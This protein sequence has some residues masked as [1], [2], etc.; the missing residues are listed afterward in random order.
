[1]PDIEGQAPQPPSGPRLLAWT[2]A[3][4]VVAAAITVCFV[5]PA[6][7]HRDPLGV[8]KLTGLGRLAAPKEVAAPAPPA[9]AAA[10]PARFYSAPWRTDEIV[11]DLPGD[12]A[13]GSE[14]EYKV[15]MKPGATLVY[16]WSETG[17]PPEEF[18]SD[19]HGQTIPAKLGSD[20]GIKVATYRQT[21]GSGGSGALVAPLDG[22]HG[23]YLQNQA[24]KAA[25]VT[26]KLAGF[27][28]LVPPGQTGNETGILPKGQKPAP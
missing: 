5:M 24:V 10:T 20:E 22:V 17:A 27:Y 21:T 23:W 15:R 16:S 28:E 13:P 1:M 14:L 19:F 26:L 8:G 7:F 9:G 11:I 12:A 6:E 4:F 18:Y 3:A 25:R 2:G